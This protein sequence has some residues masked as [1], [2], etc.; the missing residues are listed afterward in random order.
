MAKKAAKKAKVKTKKVLKAAKGVQY[1]T[2]DGTVYAQIE[3]RIDVN[4]DDIENGD[5]GDATSCAIALAVQR[6]TGCND[7]EVGGEDISVEGFERPVGVEKQLDARLESFVE[8][9][10]DSET[11]GKVK[12]F[13]FVLKLRKAVGEAVEGLC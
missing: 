2:D 3:R 8:R 10:D 1:V 11:R 13:S 4:A 5:P 7:V 12:P 6:T 9:F